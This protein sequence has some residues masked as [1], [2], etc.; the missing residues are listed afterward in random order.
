MEQKKSVLSMNQSTLSN[1]VIYEV[2][3]TVDF[4]IADIFKNWLCTHVS[5]MLTFEGFTK[6][7]WFERESSEEANQGNK[8]HWTIHYHVESKSQLENYFQHHASQ[9]RQEGI[10]Q[11]GNKFSATRRIL[12]PLN[13]I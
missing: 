12:Y 13:L 9:M 3:L 8:K 7:D 6:A 2:N 1:N 4:D 11:F 10:D 5:T